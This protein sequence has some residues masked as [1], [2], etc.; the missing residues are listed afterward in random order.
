MRK[1]I[2]G[3]SR[4]SALPSPLSSSRLMTTG[5]EV[6]CADLHVAGADAEAAL[7]L[8]ELG[9]VP[10]VLAVAAGGVRIRVVAR[11]GVVAAAAAAV[12]RRSRAAVLSA[13]DDVGAVAGGRAARTGVV[14]ADF[15]VTVAV[16]RAID[17]AV[18]GDVS[19]V[20]A[21]SSCWLALLR[22]GAVE[23]AALV[24]DAGLLVAGVGLAALPERAILGPAVA[25][26][27]GHGAARAVIAPVVPAIADVEGAA[28]ART[29]LAIV[30]AVT[31]HSSVAARNS[32]ITA[33]ATHRRRHHPAH[34]AQGTHTNP[35]QLLGIS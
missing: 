26:G 15:A 14:D 25:H 20:V 13:D 31:A 12:R 10:V 29:A 19:A 8:G 23:V 28:G 3:K 2:S 32:R 27:R 21:A 24:V 4:S 16:D 22:V 33:A 11:T 30:A 9:A 35:H 5:V 1:T 34:K 7:A 18:T 6:L 17:V